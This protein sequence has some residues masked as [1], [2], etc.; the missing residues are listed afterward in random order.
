[1]TDL[2]RRKSPRYPVNVPA[3]LASVAGT[4]SGKVKDLCR[5]AAL[6][7]TLQSIPVGSPVEVTLEVPGAAAPLV[8]RGRVVREAE[9]GDGHPTVAVLFTEETPE[10]ATQLDFL[11]DSTGE[12]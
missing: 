3:R 11:I 8:I 7:E 6:F 10:F 4:F 5:D 9:A 1:M 2:E 12:E